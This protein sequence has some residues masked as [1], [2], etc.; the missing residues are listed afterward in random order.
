MYAA[1]G[2][3]ERSMKI[4]CLYNNDI[5]LELFDW[6]KSNGHEIILIK[7]ALEEDWCVKH[8][9]DLAV[10][11]TYRH[12]LT[13]VILTA[14]GHKAVNLH[15]SYLP[16]NKGADPNLWSIIEDTPRG[17]TL[18]YMD[19]RLDHG[20]IIA[21]SLCPFR[22]SNRNDDSEVTLVSTYAELD[23]EAKKLFKSAVAN[24]PYWDSMR[25]RTL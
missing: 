11:Y 21:Q 4:L 8:G 23:T 22:S 5:A 18:H 15:I 20:D 12:I 25:K 6:I 2:K 9:F 24:Y 10:S 16:W 17:V 14:L 1:F 3:G 19:S 13:E 7:D